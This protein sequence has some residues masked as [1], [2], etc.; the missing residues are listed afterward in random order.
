MASLH[1]AVAADRSQ[2]QGA[3]VHDRAGLGLG[4]LLTP[5]SSTP[6]FKTP[7]HGANEDRRRPLMSDR[8]SKQEVSGA[9]VDGRRPVTACPQLS[10]EIA[11]IRTKH[12]L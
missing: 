3:R 6:C 8:P 12:F 2:S 9:A 5:L 1:A 4:T 11:H 7:P 10:T